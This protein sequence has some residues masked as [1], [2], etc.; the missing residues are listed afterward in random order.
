MLSWVILFAGLTPIAAEEN[1]LVKL[2][3]EPSI[4]LI[5]DHKYLQEELVI[6][7]EINLNLTNQTINLV[8][9]KDK[10]KVNFD[11]KNDQAYKWKFEYKK[12]S[13]DLTKALYTP[14]YKKP[15]MWFVIGLLGGMYAPK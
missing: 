13:K 4:N 3:K 2:Y 8:E 9:Q 6:Q 14:F 1:N 15:I 10:W 7:K 5:V 11:I 12:C